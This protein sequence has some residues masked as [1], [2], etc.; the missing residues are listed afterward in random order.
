MDE[1]HV[2]IFWDTGFFF[3]GTLWGERE[4]DVWM[5][6]CTHHPLGEPG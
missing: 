3:Q 1:L 5:W 2:L 4:I 6:N